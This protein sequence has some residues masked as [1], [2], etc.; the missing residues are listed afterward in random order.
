[1]AKK[2]NIDYNILQGIK[3][4]MILKEIPSWSKAK[5]IYTEYTGMN[6]SERTLSKRAKEIN[7]DNITI[8]EVE[9]FLES[10]IKEKHVT[11]KYDPNTQF[12]FNDTIFDLTLDNGTK[13]IQHV[14]GI[15]EEDKE[16][17][18]GIL[19]TDDVF[20]QNKKIMDKLGN[21]KFALEYLGYNT[22]EYE[23]D[24]IERSS[25]PTPMKLKLENG[26]H[27]PISVSNSR[28]NLNVKKRKN[29][30]IDPFDVAK[31]MIDIYKDDSE[32]DNYIKKLQ[33]INFFHITP[34]Y[35]N[36]DSIL[37]CH[38]NDLHFGGL[39]H[40][41][42]TGFSN[43]D[44][45]I[46]AAT[47]Y[48]ILKYC[49]QRNTEVWK[50]KNIYLVLNG[51]ILDIDNFLS[52]TTSFSNHTMQTDSRW[53]K[54]FGNALAIIQHFIIE[55]SK[56][57]ENV[58]VD[59]TPGN[60]DK[61]SMIALY[62]CL[63]SFF[64]T[65][66]INNVHM[67]VGDEALLKQQIFTYG[68]HLFISDHGEL[69]DQSLIKNLEVTYADDIS[70][71]SYTTIFAGH[72]HQPG[73][74]HSGNLMLL[75]DPSLCP[76]TTFE[77]NNTK[78]NGKAIQ[79]QRFRLWKS[80]ER[81]PIETNVLEFP[82]QRL[83]KDPEIILESHPVS[84]PQKLREYLIEEG[85]SKYT[86]RQMLLAEHLLKNHNNIK[87]FIQQNNGN[88]SKMN[89]HDT[90]KIATELGIEIP[91]GLAGENVDYVLNNIDKIIPNEAYLSLKLQR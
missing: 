57:F 75:R 77:K 12:E 35:N 88:G 33:S 15:S 73:E 80:N 9:D 91:P 21:E 39:T 55:L 83:W 81:M 56:Y 78:L 5:K 1:M 30:H 69:S 89:Y 85:L 70:K 45:K 46:A 61:Q 26:R 4:L 62:F 2:Y 48:E 79:A 41:L 10:Y 40:H 67:K 66:K 25:W 34:S 23:I 58:Y 50:A 7:E 28:F 52:K 29:I 82:R 31:E 36:E 74:Y 90:Y 8:K 20:A 18:F 44:S 16:E 27:I 65:S 64:S 32:F 13:A 19:P 11:L 6:I 49:I 24:K 47:L 59:V 63:L 60:H 71:A 87:E 51:D 53:H 43:W 84:N 54:M 72:T 76:P 42:E 86:Q 37:T 38:I 17:I 22:V 3:A 14:I 68:K